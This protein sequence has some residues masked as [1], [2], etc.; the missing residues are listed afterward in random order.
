VR[1]IAF[2]TEAVVEAVCSPGFT[3]ELARRAWWAMEDAEDARRMLCNPAIVSGT[4]GPVLVDHLIG[5]LPF[6]TENDKIMESIRLVVQTR[7][8]GCGSACRPLDKSR[9]Q[10]GISRRLPAGTPRRSAGSRESA[11]AAGADFHAGGGRQHLRS[12]HAPGLLTGRTG[13][14]RDRGDRL[15]EAAESGCGDHDL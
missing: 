12:A 11:R 7:T 5:Y 13:L 8:P 10:P 9:G 6:E 14:P 15:G 1:S 2:V 4:M 3:A